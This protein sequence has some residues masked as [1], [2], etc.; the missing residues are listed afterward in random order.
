M[1]IL[2]DPFVGVLISVMMIKF[3]STLFSFFIEAT[4]NLNA[5]LANRIT[6]FIIHSKYFSVSDWLKAHP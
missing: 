6:T 1:I 2:R 4:G 5:V 3:L